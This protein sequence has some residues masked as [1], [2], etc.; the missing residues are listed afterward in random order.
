ME[1]LR[2][3]LLHLGSS[4]HTF[5]LVGMIA[6]SWGGTAIEPWMSPSALH[7]CGPTSEAIEDR[8]QLSTSSSP[9][10]GLSYLSRA[11]SLS[12]GPGARCG[13]PQVPGTLWNTMIAP[14][15]PLRLAAFRW[16]QGAVH[17]GPCHD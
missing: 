8:V 14:L 6:A 13:I 1:P 16:Y 12:D 2:Q 5:L 7:E 11:A 3:D 15:L 9:D 10:R 17:C 4:E